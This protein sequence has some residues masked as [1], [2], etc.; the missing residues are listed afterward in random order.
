MLIA[1]WPGSCCFPHRQ[2]EAGSC[3]A[4]PAPLPGSRNKDNQRYLQ[5]W[6]MTVWSH[7]DAPTS[8]SRALHLSWG[9]AP[10]RRD[11][12]LGTAGN[13]RLPWSHKQT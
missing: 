6:A 4:M 7:Q 11:T 10:C 13:G 5:R 1:H 8:Q 9:R 12:L 2:S 3:A